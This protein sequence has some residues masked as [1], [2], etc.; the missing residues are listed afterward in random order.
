MMRI[1]EIMLTG[2]LISLAIPA[3]MFAQQ[4]Q[5][6]FTCNRSNVTPA[7][8]GSTQPLGGPYVPVADYAVELNTGLLVY[9]ECVLRVIIDHQRKALTSSI[10]RQNLQQF[11]TGRNGQPMYLREM[12][13]EQKAASDERALQTINSQILQ[14]FPSSYQE[15]IKRAMAASYLNTVDPVRQFKC[16]YNG[17]I[18]EVHNG[19]VT[20]SFYAALNAL[21]FDPGCNQLDA[22]IKADRVLD[23]QSGY[24]I[25]EMM[26][27]LDYGQ[28]TYPV[29]ERNADG[30]W[31]V[32]TPAP[33][34]LA[35]GIMHIQSGYRQLQT[36]D[37]LGEMIDGL[38]AGISTQILNGAG[39]TAPTTGLS[40]SGLGG[41][42]QG[43][44]SYFDRVVQTMTQGYVGAT[45]NAA[46]GIL[47]EAL[48]VEKLY[49]SA[50][51]GAASNLTQTIGS[52]RETESKCFDLIINAVCQSG[53]YN[54]STCTAQGG[55]TLTVATSSAFSQA[56]VEAKIRPLATPLTANINAS[57]QIIEKINQLISTLTANPTQAAQAAALAALAALQPHNGQAVAQAQGDAQNI[58]QLMTQL[59]D[60]ARTD[61]GDSADPKIG[62]C[63]IN[64][65][66]VTDAWKSCWSGNQGACLAP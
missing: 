14:G 32:R 51:S 17:D 60:K 42:L 47:Q 3:T 45:F 33:V 48:R 52:L 7:S 65:T 35:N 23:Y 38:Y 37:D 5:E 10:D 29:M 27:M 40:S 2:L 63:N 44:P 11:E 56:I 34:V 41:L 25:Y 64:N 54:G 18:R 46:I 19:K 59:I 31:V 21:V 57:N 53:S 62:W 26:T 15:P 20:G 36:A 16:S 55:G 39:G 8:A 13:K 28:G 58:S 9:K 24:E 12:L 49:N 66:A 43:A 6:V 4:T 1:R 50:V 61:W 30:R 22:Y